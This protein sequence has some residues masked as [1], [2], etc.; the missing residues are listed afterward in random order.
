MKISRQLNLTMTLTDDEGADVHVHAVPISLEVFEANVLP[1]S[2]TFAL[3]YSE[4]LARIAGPRAAAMIL[5]SVCEE[6]YP[7]GDDRG[8][9]IYSRIM[10]D[11]HR[12]TMVF[13][14]SET[15]WEPMLFD[16]AVRRA[17]LDRETASEVDGALV[18]FSLNWRMLLRT[19][20]EE[21]LTGAMALWGGRMSSL[22]ST[23][24]GRSLPTST[25]AAATGARVPGSSVPS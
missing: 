21:V 19:Q 8:S 10:A 9:Q 4:G 14:P 1:L 23:D 22:N 18:F 24:F 11:V 5:K 12:T 20:R 17:V 25:T 6:S 2:K 13:V 3:I 15:G 16:E 7:V